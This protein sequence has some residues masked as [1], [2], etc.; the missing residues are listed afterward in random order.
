MNCILQ[1]SELCVL[2]ILSQKKLLKT[3]GMIRGQYSGKCNLHGERVCRGLRGLY[4]EGPDWRSVKARVNF[5][6]TGCLL[7]TEG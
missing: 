1:N 6:K 4:S 5:G 2:G 7:L 3:E